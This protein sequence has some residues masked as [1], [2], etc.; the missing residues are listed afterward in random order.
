MAHFTSTSALKMVHNGYYFY[1]PAGTPFWI[2]DSMV[3]AFVDDPG[4]IIPGLSWT[5]FEDPVSGGTSGGNLVSN[6]SGELMPTNA[7]TSA[8]FDT[9]EKGADNATYAAGSITV[10][11]W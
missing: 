7:S 1:G 8:A 6:A 2:P 5:D 11:G 9:E 3:E 10:T 4:P